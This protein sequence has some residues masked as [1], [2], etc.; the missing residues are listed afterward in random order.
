MSS[1][2]GCTLANDELPCIETAKYDSFKSSFSIALPN[3]TENYYIAYQRCCR[4]PTLQNIDDSGN[5]GVTYFVEI[6]P[7]TQSLCNI[8]PV[9]NEVPPFVFCSNIPV[10]ADLSATDWDGDSLVYALTS[11]FVGGGPDLSSDGYSTC[12][13]ANPTPDCPPPYKNVQYKPG[14]SANNPLN[15]EERFGQTF[16]IDSETGLLTG[17]ASIIGTYVIGVEVLEYRNGVYLGKTNRDF[18]VSVVPSNSTTS[19]ASIV[20][21]INNFQVTPNPT[22]NDLHLTIDLTYKQ[23][24][25]IVL[26][27]LVGQSIFEKEYEDSAIF[28][29]IPVQGIPA[30]IYFLSLQLDGQ[31]VSKKVVIN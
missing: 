16:Q 26:Q 12:S 3:S 13:G 17:V 14:F 18:Q 22:D 23:P 1:P 7:H 24:S 2:N 5:V 30:G 29:T 11:P 10:T 8:S 27:N 9:F 31:V 6:P 28:T 25:K 4:I 15:Q 20:T 19:I 21:Q